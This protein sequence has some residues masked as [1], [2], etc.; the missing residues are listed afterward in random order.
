MDDA[1]AAAD[2]DDDDDDNNDVESNFVFSIHRSQ[3]KAEKCSSSHLLGV[4]GRVAL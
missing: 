3:V 2:D 1:A 4:A